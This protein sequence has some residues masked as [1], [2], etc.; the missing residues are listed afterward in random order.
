MLDEYQK[1]EKLN[2][3]AKAYYAIQKKHEVYHE[4]IKKYNQRKR[5]T[6]SD[7][8]KVFIEANN[9]A[10]EAWY[11]SIEKT[12]SKSA[13]VNTAVA[14]LFFYKKNSLY[15]EKFYNLDESVFKKINKLSSNKGT[16]YG[17]KIAKILVCTLDEVIN[18]LEPLNT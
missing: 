8:C 10:R 6:I 5:K 13:S 2:S 4:Q 18:E 15:F 14:N 7:K 17:C 11:R 16:Y 12:P 9:I 1:A 3:V